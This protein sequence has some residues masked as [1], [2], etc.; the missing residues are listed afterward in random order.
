MYQQI[1][2][3]GNVGKDPDMRYTQ[4]GAG[5]CSFSVA[6]NRRWTNADGSKGEKTTWFKISAWN[7]LG[8]ICNQYVRKGMLILVNGEVEVS[9]FTGNDGQQ[10]YSLDIRAS[11]VKFLSSRNET[12][13]NEGGYD[14]DSNYGGGGGG[15]GYQQQPRGREED[16]PF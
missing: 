6:V 1:T 7:K 2:I 5:V 15:G 16:I 3:V 8:E 11:D 14:D 4:T 13:G 12:Y 9:T 10:R